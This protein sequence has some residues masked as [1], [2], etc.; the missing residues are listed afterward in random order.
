MVPAA[1]VPFSAVDEPGAGTEGGGV[2]GPLVDAPE[3]DADDP[4]VRR[5]LAAV[6]QRLVGAT[7]RLE[8]GRFVVEDKLGEGG[9]GVVYRAQDRQLDRAVA[10]KLLH[11]GF[12]GQRL[13]QEARAL[14]RLSHPNV[15]QVFD[16]GQFEGRTFVVME[17]VD[18]VTLRRWLAQAP[19]SV[20]EILSVFADAARGLR[21][22][23]RA[24]I[25]H[26]DFKPDN[27]LVG[28]D[29]RVRVVDFGLAHP[30]AVDPTAEQPSLAETPLTSQLT[31]TGSIVGTP[32][33]MA[34]EQ[35]DAEAEVD[36][37]ADQF[38]LCVALFEALHGRRP[39]DGRT[40]WEV[41]EAAKLPVVVPTKSGVPRRVR[42]V[43]A[44][45]LSAAPHA[46][47][48]TLDPVL[49][50][51]EL[52]AR[53]R[54]LLF[55]VALPLVAVAIGA[56]VWLTRSSDPAAASC[57]PAQ[58]L[59]AGT[60][61]AERADALHEGLSGVALPYAADTAT[62]ARAAVEAWADDWS[63][64][65]DEVCASLR[66]PTAG[67]A[68]D[69]Q[70]ECLQ[71]QL[72]VVDST[73]T[74][75]SAAD[76]P[77]LD[78]T[79]GIVTSLPEPGACL[80]TQLAPVPAEPDR[81][82][83]VRDVRDELARA[84]AL[85]R[86]GDHEAAQAR[87]D[88]QAQVVETLAFAPLSAELDLR[89]A[90]LARTRGEWEQAE[91]LHERA[92]F[93]A[94]D[95][96]HARAAVEAAT[97]LVFVVGSRLG[98]HDD[99]QTWSRHAQTQLE[100]IGGDDRMAAVLSSNLGSVRRH[101]GRLEEAL[102]LY[103]RAVELRRAALGHDD[104]K[105]AV[106]EQNVGTVLFDLGR[107]DEGFSALE[108]A[109]GV[110]S[111][112]YG[113]DHPQLAQAVNNVGAALYRVGRYDEAAPYLERAAEIRER[114]LGPTHP[115]VGRSLSN[116]GS[117]AKSRGKLAEAVAYHRRALEVLEAS[118]GSE[119]PDLAIA[120]GNL[121]SAQQ[122]LGQ[123]DDAR[124]SYERSLAI[125]IAAFGEQ[126]PKVAF[127]RKA[128]GT[129]HIARGD[130]EA[131]IDELDRALAVARAVYPQPHPDT[132]TI[133]TRRADARLR[134]HRGA[135]ALRDAEEAMQIRAAVG[136]DPERLA[137]TR[138]VLAR[139]LAQVDPTDARARTEAR[140]AADAYAA[141]GEGG[142]EHVAE[143][144]AWLAARPP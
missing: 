39:Y 138:F 75:L 33:Y 58:R 83:K 59:L 5:L 139:A 62:R 130:H 110:Q 115:L 34:P 102:E 40:L 29:G 9:M 44:R 74:G 121:A 13:Q 76:E 18:G 122:D 61:D 114:S 119:H 14:A 109:L 26:R 98:R 22:A 86:L 90:A 123:L 125:R 65:Y 36:A 73:I 129:L 63:A 51:L 113:P 20:A 124:S 64:A 107:F 117:L 71:R 38:S 96:D 48:P 95:H 140:A 104:D 99:A 78:R 41:L 66:A 108:H 136:P 87:L 12:G 105:V 85:H 80:Q 31:V 6:R 88:D 103:R 101:E 2:T 81:A 16:V 135:E 35:A 137:E 92:F 10:V 132:A 82:A 68:P 84:R 111:S 106:F 77:Q 4:E 89:R 97:E 52:P 54:G 91:R 134:L 32:A 17:L 1:L 128:L 53:S 50:A 25:V 7:E 19:R 30:L 131:A 23:H 46:R 120:L 100:R 3:H 37:R 70:L 118:Q 112:V 21:A 27:V 141:L 116:L 49:A 143:I 11:A 94:R 57:P 93:A 127:A 42:R 144:D 43:L 69:R 8:I 67:T 142:R 28:E 47:F 56:G 55:A 15:V 24:G 79:L 133:L 72:G 126:H 45:G 60:W